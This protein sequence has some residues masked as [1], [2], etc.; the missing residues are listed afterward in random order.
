MAHIIHVKMFLTWHCTT[1]GF[2]LVF[3]SLF[4]CRSSSKERRAND[5]FYAQ[6][7]ERAWPQLLGCQMYVFFVLCVSKPVLSK[8]ELGSQLWTF[9][10]Y[11][12]LI[13]EVTE[14]DL[15]PKVTED[16]PTTED[17]NIYLPIP[18]SL[19]INYTKWHGVGWDISWKKTQKPTKKVWDVITITVVFCN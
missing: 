15:L 9:W 13:D 7:P 4:S 5:N 19:K 3:S 6:N 8:W 1:S 18:G 2:S 11:T 14:P 10:S 16:N 12:F 17:L